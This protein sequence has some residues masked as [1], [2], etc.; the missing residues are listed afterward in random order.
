MR[1]SIEKPTRIG[2][3]SHKPALAYCENEEEANS[4][5]TVNTSIDSFETRTKES[6][7]LG[8]QSQ[9]GG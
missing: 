4:K 1:D 7:S 8:L 3:P 9:F 6:S 2:V 5:L